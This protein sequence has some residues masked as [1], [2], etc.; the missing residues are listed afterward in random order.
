MQ[1]AFGAEG[2][3]IM[4]VQYN[5]T[6]VPSSA[7]YFLPETPL[8]VVALTVCV[9]VCVMHGWVLW[10]GLGRP[11]VWALFLVLGRDGPDLILLWRARGWQIRLHVDGRVTVVVGE[12]ESRVCTVGLTKRVCVVRSP[13]TRCTQRET[14]QMV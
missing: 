14:Y 12:G 13:L 2:L 7:G 4:D 5:D 1:E 6:Q 11:C 9:L 10:C 3:V 8:L